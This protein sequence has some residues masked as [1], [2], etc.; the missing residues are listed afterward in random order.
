M[1]SDVS[2]LHVVVLLCRLKFVQN[3]CWLEDAANRH[4]KTIWHVLLSGQKPCSMPFAL[5]LP[6]RGWRWELVFISRRS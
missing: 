5:T 6:C 4:H 2:G 3:P 1:L